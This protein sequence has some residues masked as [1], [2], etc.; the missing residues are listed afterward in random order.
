MILDDNVPEAK[1]VD[2]K[3]VALARARSR[4]ILTNDFNLNKVA[5]L[6]GSGFSTS[7]RSR[8]Q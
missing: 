8:T 1:E 6:Q 5:E 3:L 4:T 7:T 2:A